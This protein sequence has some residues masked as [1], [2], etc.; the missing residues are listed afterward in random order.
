VGEGLEVDLAVVGGDCVS[1]D[2][3]ANLCGQ[4][5]KGRVGAVRDGAVDNCQ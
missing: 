4:A 3:L 1:E 5:Q 2:L